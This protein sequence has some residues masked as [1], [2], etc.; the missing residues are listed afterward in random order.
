MIGWGSAA[1]IE[2]VKA[3]G[4]PALEMVFNGMTYR[5]YREEWAAQPGELPRTAVSATG[6]NSVMLYASWNGATQITGYE[7][8]L[9]ET[10]DSLAQE[11]TVPR[12]GF[13]TAV[14]LSALDPST[15]VF[16]VRPVHA[17]GGD[18]PFSVA[19]Y[20]I[21]QPQCLDLLTN[22]AYFPLLFPR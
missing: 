14:E 12:S 2:E 11:T 22:K 1:K 19:A 20:R 15:C 4:S 7:I 9:G 18:M 17:D 5:A 8:Y 10:V 3:D 13:E 21:E 6:A 16:K